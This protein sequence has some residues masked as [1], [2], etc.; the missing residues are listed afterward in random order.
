M[1]FRSVGFFLLRRCRRPVYLIGTTKLRHDLPIFQRISNP[2]K[3]LRA[4]PAAA[5]D[6]SARLQEQP[7]RDELFFVYQSD[8]PA[9]APAK[10]SKSIAAPDSKNRQ[11]PRSRP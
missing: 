8:R 7:L 9:E 6:A 3:R 10:Q 5:A 2:F 11:M 4:S 1:A